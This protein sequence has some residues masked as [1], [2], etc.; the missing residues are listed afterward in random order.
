[1][2]SRYVPAGLPARGLAYERETLSAW[3]SRERAHASR[4]LV[5]ARSTE[6]PSTPEVPG[7]R[8]YHSSCSRSPLSPSPSFSLVPASRTDSS[9][10]SLLLSLS[11]SLPHSFSLFLAR[12]RA[13][14]PSFSLAPTGFF[15]RSFRTALY[16]RLP[17]AHFPDTLLLRY[18][19]PRCP[20]LSLSHSFVSGL[21][22]HRVRIQL[23]RRRV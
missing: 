4:V 7:S 22:P 6:R 18:H 2:F 17:S 5:I 12:A 23:H 1:M 10:H 16:L 11:L 15:A 20:S 13:H 21:F 19:S 3:P 14:P 8:S 9:P